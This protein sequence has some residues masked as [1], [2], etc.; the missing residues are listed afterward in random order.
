MDYGMKI[1]K[2]RADDLRGQDGEAVLRLL[3]D[4]GR[5]VLEP[6]RSAE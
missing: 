2:G 6:F 5:L 1:G 3:P 4:R